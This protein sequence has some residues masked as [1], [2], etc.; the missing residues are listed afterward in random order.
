MK[1]RAEKEQVEVKERE[2]ARNIYSMIPKQE[3]G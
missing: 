2:I 1:H 3:T